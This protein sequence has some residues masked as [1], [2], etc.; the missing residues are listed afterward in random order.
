MAQEDTQRDGA[1]ASALLEVSNAMVRLFKQQFGRGPTKSRTHFA[2][3]DTLV[4]V[5]ENTFTPSERNMVTMG[6]HQRLRDVRLFFQHASE[7][8]F[9]QT[10]EAIIGR[11][12]KSFGSAT[13]TMTDTAFEIFVLEPADGPGADAGPS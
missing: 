11:R 10:I 8:E 4:C 6:E 3:P 2:G 7:N 9:R 12:V 13:D 5:L 1:S